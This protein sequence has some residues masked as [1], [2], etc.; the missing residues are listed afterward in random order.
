MRSERL[1]MFAAFA[2]TIFLMLAAGLASMTGHPYVV[3]AC[4]VSSV[5]LMV[6]IRRG[7]HALTREEALAQ[8]ADAKEQLE[9][10]PCTRYVLE[11]FE[12]WTEIENILR[13]RG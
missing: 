6:V 13:E 11:E 12:R 4:I 5:A 10:M 1:W 3:M 8:C 7:T 2:M 9:R